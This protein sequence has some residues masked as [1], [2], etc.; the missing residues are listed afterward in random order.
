[1]YEGL[2]YETDYRNTE[3]PDHGY[4]LLVSLKWWALRDEAFSLIKLILGHSQL[5]WLELTTKNGP[6]YRVASA[7]GPL[8]DRMHR[9]KFTLMPHV[10]PKVMGLENVLQSH[11]GMPYPIGVD[12]CMGS[13]EEWS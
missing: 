4:N 2:Q 8:K 1:M 9:N 11:E 13:R 10:T 3:I 5:L 6:L 7:K 12:H